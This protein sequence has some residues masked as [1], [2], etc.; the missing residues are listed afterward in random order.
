MLKLPSF[1]KYVEEDGL[2]LTMR[3]NAWTCC[4]I[5]Q[6]TTTL[7]Y[8]CHG[9][10]FCS[11]IL[12]L[13]LAPCQS[14]AFYMACPIMNYD[15]RSFMGPSNFLLPGLLLL[16]PTLLFLSPSLQDASEVDSCYSVD[17]LW[18]VVWITSGVCL[19]IYNTTWWDIFRLVHWWKKMY[20]LG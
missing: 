11:M 13:P 6:R 16:S 8:C 5:Q 4:L 12:A 9:K 10:P 2:M 1:M 7:H 19:D 15:Q 14:V 3:E 20:R 17:I 18:P